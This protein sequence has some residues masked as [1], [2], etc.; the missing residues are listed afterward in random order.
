MSRSSSGTVS[1]LCQYCLNGTLLKDRTVILVTHSVDVCCKAEACEQVVRLEN[2][3]IVRRDHPSNVLDT[4]SMMSID[5]AEADENEDGPEQPEKKEST[6]ALET[7]EST[8]VS[9]S[10]ISWR[11]YAAY[12]VAYGGVIYWTVYAFVN[13]V[14]HVLMLAQG[15]WVGVWVNARDRDERLSFYFG[16]Y[17]A[18]QIAGGVFL[19]LMYLYLIAGAISASS[20]LHR[21]LT[22]SIFKAP[23]RWF[24][25]TPLGRIVNR[26]SKGMHLPLARLR[27]RLC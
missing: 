11:V 12:L 10:A 3:R 22:D 18:I 6:Q 1:H 25:G 14:A 23:I 15:A 9:Q 20:K 5:K 7:E 21:R 2:G 24:D 17:S 8:G 4:T 19:T 27:G 16:I 26:F 13:V